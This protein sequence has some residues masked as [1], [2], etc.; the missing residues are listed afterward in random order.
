MAGAL[1]SDSEMLPVLALM[2]ASVAQLPPDGHAKAQPGAYVVLAVLD[3][4]MRC[5]GGLS[6]GPFGA[7]AAC[8][9]V[10]Y[11]HWPCQLCSHG[12][13]FL[14]EKGGDPFWAEGIQVGI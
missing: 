8:E 6:Q 9:S 1:G 4:S 14:G 13:V 3:C 5:A 10:V 7:Y 2:V 11:E 12:R